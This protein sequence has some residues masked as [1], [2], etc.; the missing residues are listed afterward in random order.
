MG[1]QHKLRHDIENNLWTETSFIPE[2]KHCF[3]LEIPD[4]NNTQA[5]STWSPPKMLVAPTS[6][7]MPNHFD[8]TS[9]QTVATG[10]KLEIPNHKRVLHGTCKYGSLATSDKFSNTVQMILLF[11][12]SQGWNIKQSKEF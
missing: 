9:G 4:G 7:R 3:M 8:N 6:W 1:S 11:R 5:F 2:K 10:I 12:M